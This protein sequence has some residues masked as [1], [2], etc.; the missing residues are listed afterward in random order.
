[1]NKKL[2]ILMILLGMVYFTYNNMVTTGILLH[3]K[4]KE[5]TS[6]EEIMVKKLQPLAT[7]SYIN[8]LIYSSKTSKNCV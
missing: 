2:F 1:M 8:N 6:L 5:K 4:K 7:D 3:H